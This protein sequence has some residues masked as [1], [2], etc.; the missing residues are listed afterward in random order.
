MTQNDWFDRMLKTT[1][2]KPTAQKE[3]K[4]RT[5]AVGE[6]PT[7]TMPK[8]TRMEVVCSFCEETTKAWNWQ[9]MIPQHKRKEGVSLSQ[10]TNSK[11]KSCTTCHD[12]INY[13]FSLYEQAEVYNNVEKMKAEMKK[14]GLI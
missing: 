9:H 7:K 10:V 1:K 6:L 5:R 2:Q 8:N 12:K 14:R 3:L 13:Y 4:V 11:V